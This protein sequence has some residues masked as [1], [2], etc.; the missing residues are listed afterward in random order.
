[1]AELKRKLINMSFNKETKSIDLGYQVIMPEIMLT[2]L[3]AELAIEKVAVMPAMMILYLHISENL[4]QNIFLRKLSFQAPIRSEHAKYIYTTWARELQL[5][6]KR[7]GFH[8]FWDGD[9]ASTDDILWYITYVYIS[10]WKG[11][12]FF[13]E[14]ETA[15]ASLKLRMVNIQLIHPEIH[16]IRDGDWEKHIASAYAK[17]ISYPLIST[18][19]AEHEKVYISIYISPLSRGRER[20]WGDEMAGTQQFLCFISG[21]NALSLL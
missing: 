2:E 3:A 14:M 20:T 15:S 1:M 16:R 13:S 5:F 17:R 21:I 4:L 12:C 8:P 9:W 10:N 11:M 18:A 6:E 19:D 7:H